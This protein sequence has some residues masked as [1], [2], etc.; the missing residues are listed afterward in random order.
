MQT[1]TVSIPVRKATFTDQVLFALLIGIFLFVLT[2]GSS[3]IGFELAYAGKIYPGVSVA[4]IQLS[5]LTPAQAA[6][7]LTEQF[8]FPQKGRIF[9]QDG[10][11]AW[12][13]TPAELGLYLDPEHS[14][15]QAYQIGR[16]SDLMS[17]LLTQFHTSQAPVNLP[18]ILVFDQRQGATYLSGVIAAQLNKP[19][20]EASVGLNGVDVVVRS[21]QSGRQLDLAASLERITAQLQSLQD[22]VIPLVMIESQPVILDV[23]AQ[24]ELARKI[25]SQPLTIRMPDGQPDAHGPW[26]FDVKTLASML[27]L[28]RVQN[29]DG[30]AVYEISVDSSKLRSYL[31]G[32]APTLK[33][34]PQNAHYTFNESAKSWK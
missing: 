17:A 29:P 7:R 22:G 28:E 33:L 3:L 11:M 8:A 34:D 9:L 1:T 27:N 16:T 21:G 31:Q 18:P 10:Q 15:A 23:T 30:S 4:D 26:V 2:A 12:K 13:V 6:A 14:V 32:L 19:V 20:V 24:A 25:L 5:G